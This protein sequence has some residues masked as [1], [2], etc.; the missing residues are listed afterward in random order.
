MDSDVS[1]NLNTTIGAL[2]IGVLVSYMLFGVTTTQTYIYYSRFPED[3][4]KLKALVGFV[5]W[6]ELAHALCIGHSLYV[7]TIS[8][9]LQPALLLAAA[10]KSLETTSIFSGLISACVQGFFSY[11]IY[12][13]SRKLCIPILIWALSFLRLLGNI[14]IFV[15]ALGMKSLPGYVEQW[16][17]LHTSIWSTSTANDLIIAATLVVL[18][19]NQSTNVHKRTAALVDKLILWTIETGVLTS[20]SGVIALICFVT[21]KTNFIWMVLWV[22]S[23]RRDV[24]EFP[25]GKPQRKGDAPHD[26]RSFH[27]IFAF[28]TRNWV[29]LQLGHTEGATKI[30][31]FHIY[32]GG[33]LFVQE[34]L[35]H[36]S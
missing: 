21:M 28:D 29:A 30:G 4:R 31:N 14:V 25:S 10:P 8:D 22:I 11:R 23:A 2:Q 7:Y 1:F 18:L 26:E 27:A 5:W 36:F 17:W 32:V 12:S 19:R 35:D 6:C 13:F 15:A 16:Q 33:G 20:A 34:E 24:L 9:Y 3:S